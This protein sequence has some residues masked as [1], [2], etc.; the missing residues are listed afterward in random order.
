MHAKETLVDHSSPELVKK[1]FNT[2]S[3][4]GAGDVARLLFQVITAA[5]LHFKNWLV[6]VGFSL[7]GVYTQVSYFIDWI[8]V[9]RRNRQ[10]Q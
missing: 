6:T 8:A 4:L 3:S 10:L 1:P 5:N 2:E 9:S 7:S